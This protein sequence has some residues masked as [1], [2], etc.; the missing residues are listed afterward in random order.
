[1]TTQLLLTKFDNKVLIDNY[2]NDQDRI[3]ILEKLNRT[4]TQQLEKAKQ[5]LDYIKNQKNWRN[6][7]WRLISKYLV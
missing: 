4:R 7:N 6:D 3:N 1:M 5:E 2:E